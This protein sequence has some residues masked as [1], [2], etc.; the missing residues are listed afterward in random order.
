MDAA[1]QIM[2]GG[3][4]IAIGKKA[5][6]LSAIKLPRPNS[7]ADNKVVATAS[8]LNKRALR[9]HDAALMKCLSDIDPMLGKK[10]SRHGVGHGC[11]CQF[12]RNIF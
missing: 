5:S 6:F 11:T 10:M 2:I 9:K 3:S 1:S 8:R 12:Q 7:E 4:D